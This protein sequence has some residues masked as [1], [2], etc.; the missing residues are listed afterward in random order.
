MSAGMQTYIST[1]DEDLGRA[2]ARLDGILS[3]E[4]GSATKQNELLKAAAKQVSPLRGHTCDVAS[5][6]VPLLVVANS[7]R[8]SS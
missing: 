8:P 7:E 3:A 4:G 6:V 5:L 2:Q 1:L